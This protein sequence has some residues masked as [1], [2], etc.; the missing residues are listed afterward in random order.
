MH[1]LTPGVVASPLVGRALRLKSGLA[2][3]CLGD[4]PAYALR[5]VRGVGHACLLRLRTPQPLVRSGLRRILRPWI[6]LRLSPRCLAVRPRGSGVV[7]CCLRPVVEGEGHLKLRYYPLVERCIN[8]FGEPARPKYPCGSACATAMSISMQGGSPS[9]SSSADAPAQRS[10]CTGPT[11]RVSGAGGLTLPERHPCSTTKCST[12]VG[13]PMR[14]Q[15]I[16][17]RPGSTRRRARGQNV[18]C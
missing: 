18:S 15:A 6:N 8:A 17:S 14:E 9:Q 16:C 1:I 4:G 3:R 11:S 5:T 2:G 12:R 7:A 10:R 13:W